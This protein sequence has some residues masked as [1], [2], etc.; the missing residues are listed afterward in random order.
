MRREAA[1]G[2]AAAG[3]AAQ[4]LRLRDRHK[5]GHGSCKR[6]TQPDDGARLAN[7]ALHSGCADTYPGGVIVLTSFTP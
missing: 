4:L 2:W 1:A 3:L 5:D 7:A 6:L